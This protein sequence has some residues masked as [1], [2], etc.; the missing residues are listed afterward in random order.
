MIVQLIFESALNLIG[1]GKGHAIR[2]RK[3]GKNMLL[4][5]VRNAQPRSQYGVIRNIVASFVAFFTIA[6]PRSQSKIDMMIGRNWHPEATFYL[7]IILSECI[8]LPLA[9][10]PLVRNGQMLF[11]GLMYRINILRTETVQ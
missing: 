9:D 4:I 6:I 1:C 8:G 11:I 5:S 10:K 7:S 2:S 3:T